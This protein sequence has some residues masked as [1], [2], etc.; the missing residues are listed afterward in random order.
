MP[1]SLCASALSLSVLGLLAGAAPAVAQVF[2]LEHFQCYPVL[3]VDPE[4]QATVRLEDQFNTPEDVDVRRAVRFCNPTRKFHNGQV[5]DVADT[6]QHL[7]LY[8]TFPQA[9]P[10]RIALVSN[11]FGQQWLKLRGP[12]RLAAP[13]QKAPHTPP[14][15]LDHFQCY[16]AYGAGVNQAVALSD[17]FITPFTTH[18]VLDP[19]SF[20]NPVQKTHAGVVTEVQHPDLHLACY[21]MTRVRFTREAATRNQF[22]VQTIVVGPPDT[23]CVPTRKVFWQ[24]IP[25]AGVADAEAAGDVR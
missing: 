21:S 25:D 10:L 7:M 24:A 9:G 5:F 8:S 12:A 4:I 22:G 16:P 20:C 1:R 23:L 14:A 11:Q 15:G 2:E 6:R 17:Q 3:K 19:V 18:V 13:T